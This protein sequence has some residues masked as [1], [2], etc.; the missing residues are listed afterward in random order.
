MRTLVTSIGGGDVEG[1][2]EYVRIPRGDRGAAEGPEFVGRGATTT[3]DPTCRVRRRGL[4]K[5]PDN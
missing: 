4:Q 5:K 1:P 3:I 2:V